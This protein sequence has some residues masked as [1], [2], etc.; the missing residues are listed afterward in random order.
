[1]IRLRTAKN[2]NGG[3]IA[4]VSVLLISVVLLLMVTTLSLSG[5]IG[6]FSI[7]NSEL[8]KVSA[9]LAEACANTAVLKL[10]ENW[11]YTGNETIVVNGNACAVFPVAAAGADPQILKTQA[12]YRKSYTN[13]VIT[14][15]KTPFAI[16]S[17]QEVPN[18]P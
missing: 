16:V 9:S 3:F 6:R 18:L 12:V 1:M 4:L 11:N 2:S 17:W 7:L 8:K 14:V 10:A 5:F 15:H 13:L